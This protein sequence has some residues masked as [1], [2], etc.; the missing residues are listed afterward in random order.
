MAKAR[1]KS[2]RRQRAAHAPRSARRSA[3]DGQVR[4]LLDAVVDAL[5]REFEDRARRAA[6]EPVDSTP[7]NDADGAPAI[8][9]GDAGDGE[10]AWAWLE[11]QRRLRNLN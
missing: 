6:P 5:V 2:A 8:E 7:A 11:E 10:G 3:T 1:R 9:P 4:S